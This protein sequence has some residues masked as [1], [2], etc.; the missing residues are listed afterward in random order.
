[1]AKELDHTIQY[2]NA[3]YIKEIHQPYIKTNKKQ[4]QTTAHEI[5]MPKLIICEMTP[6]ATIY[7]MATQKTTTSS[8]NDNTND[9]ISKKKTPRNKDP[10]TPE[11]VTL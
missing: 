7:K 6:K 9:D 11:K 5:M 2:L 1:C 8:T 10:K 4:H 3:A